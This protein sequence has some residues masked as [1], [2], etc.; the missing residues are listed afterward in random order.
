MGQSVPRREFRR[1]EKE[2][3]RGETRREAV[4]RRPASLGGRS[5]GGYDAW[6]GD[7]NRPLTMKKEG[8]QTRNRKLSSKS[9]KKKGMLGFPDMLKPLDKGGFGGF[10]TGGSGFGSMS[11]YMYG[12]QMHGSSMAG[13]FMSAP[14]MHGVSAMSGVGLGLSSTSQIQIPSSLGLQ[15]PMVSPAVPPR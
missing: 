5:E 3:M 7:V 15:P 12:G 8:I 11:H 14:P 4:K 9:K 10:G 2:V 13:G 6:P 1:S